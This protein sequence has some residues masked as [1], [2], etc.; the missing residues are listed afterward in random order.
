MTNKTFPNAQSV[1]MSYSLPINLIRQYCFCPR[2]PYFQELLKL[3]P[4][5]PLW[6][7]QGEDFHL[8]QEKVFKYRT[9]KR[10]H[11]EQAKQEFNVFVSADNLQLHGVIDSVLLSADAIY[12]IEFKLNG[13]K[14]NKGQILQLTAYA[15]V[16]TQKYDLPCDKGFILYTNKGKTNP[17]VFKSKDK[18]QVIFIRDRIL[19][20]LEK[21]Y[22]PDSPATPAQCTQCEYLNHCNDRN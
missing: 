3:D 19:D 15:M 22:L 7:K 6:V 11:L 9:L 16:A 12:P 18:E 10:F 1:T 14:P 20:N 17:I 8:K 13:Y 21:S 2:I 5:R 4:P